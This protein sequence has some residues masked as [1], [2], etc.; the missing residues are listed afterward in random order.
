MYIIPLFMLAFSMFGAGMLCQRK[1]DDP[2]RLRSAIDGLVDQNHQLSDV[3]AQL[4]VSSDELR[5]ADVKLKDAD[6]KLA[7]RS[8]EL[9]NAASALAMSDFALKI[10]LVEER[11]HATSLSE[12]CEGL[13]K[14]RSLSGEVPPARVN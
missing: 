8:D 14:E 13:V 12:A 2:V 1:L 7:V 5:R 6:R 10:E 4:M 9:E 11:K 3:N